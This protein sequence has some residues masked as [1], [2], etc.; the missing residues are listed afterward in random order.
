MLD[1]H[2]TRPVHQPSRSLSLLQN[3]GSTKIHFRPGMPLIPKRF[4]RSHSEVNQNSILR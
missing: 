2:T 4:L 3:A 1:H